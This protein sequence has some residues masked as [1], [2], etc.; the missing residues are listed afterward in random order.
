MKKNTAM[1]LL[2]IL[3]VFFAIVAGT[4]LLFLMAWLGDDFGMGAVVAAMVVFVLL[5]AVVSTFAARR[6]K[7][8]YGLSAPKFVLLNV[9]PTFILAMLLY[10]AMYFSNLGWEAL[11]WV[12][13]AVSFG[14]YMIGYA[15]V[16]SIVMGIAYAVDRKR[17]VQ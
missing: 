15:A 3:S 16:L 14:G 9:L 1:L 17:S 6:Y 2:G 12:V 8:K 4:P 10:V 7:R 11:L 13:I 5:H